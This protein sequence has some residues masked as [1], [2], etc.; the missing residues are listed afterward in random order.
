MAWMKSQWRM[1]ALLGVG[2]FPILLSGCQTPAGGPGGWFHRQP[3]DASTYSAARP[4][5]TL[6]GTKPLY[7]SN[8]AGDDF[9]P[10]RPRR[11]RTGIVAPAAAD[12]PPEYDGQSGILGQRL[13][14]LLA[15]LRPGTEPEPPRFACGIASAN[16]GITAIRLA[17]WSLAARR[18]SRI[19][20][21]QPRTNSTRWRRNATMEWGDR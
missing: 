6:P 20:Q 5:Y 1:P 12:S 3:V 13:T 8:Y 17:I 7:L 2:I 14:P 9:S 15:S 18:R 11:T 4:T 10:M 19:G 16:R 21:G